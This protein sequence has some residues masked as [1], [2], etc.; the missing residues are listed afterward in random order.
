MDP[1]PLNRMLEHLREEG[2]GI[3]SVLIVRHGHVVTEKYFGPFEDSRR[4]IYS[5]T[6]SFTSALVGIAIEEGYLGIDQPVLDFFS[7]RTL[8][9]NDSRK[10]AITVEHLLTMSSGLDWPEWAVPYTSSANASV[11][12][13]QGKDWVKFVLDRPVREPPGSRFNYNS[14]GSH[15]LSAILQKATGVSAAAFARE[16][17]FEPLGISDLSWQPDPCDIIWGSSGIRMRPRDMA[18]FGYLYLKGGDWEGQQVVPAGWVKASTVS[19]I[20]AGFGPGYGYQW[21]IDPEG[22]HYSARGR[23]GQRIFVIPDRDMVVVF[24][25]SLGYLEMETLPESLVDS[26]VLR[27]VARP[28]HSRTHDLT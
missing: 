12:M 4:P 18:R 2:L 7:E 13:R 26:F 25:G 24:T 1:E 23:G 22:I 17:L 5:C 6:K 8:V 19:H 20:E 3:H 9:N 16:R 27:A 21:W 10:Q 28:V 11:Q 15:L 14:G